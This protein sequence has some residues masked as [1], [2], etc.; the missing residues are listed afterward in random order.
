MSEDEKIAIAIRTYVALG[1]GMVFG[2]QVMGIILDKCGHR[3]A[4]TYIL[5]NTILSCM[6]LIIQNELQ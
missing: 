6:L 3:S 1:L 4:V 2:P 5:A